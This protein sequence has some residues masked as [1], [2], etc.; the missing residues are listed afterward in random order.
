M[1]DSSASASCVIVALLCLELCSGQQMRLGSEG[2]TDDRR[3]RGGWGAATPGLRLCVVQRS[4]RSCKRPEHSAGSNRKYSETAS[5][6]PPGRAF[7]QS[8]PI[9][10]PLLAPRHLKNS[11]F[12]S[13]LPPLRTWSLSHAQGGLH[14]TCV[15]T[16]NTG[17]NT[18]SRVWHSS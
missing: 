8:E 7:R 14:T 10:L 15:Q 16:L 4:A 3:S 9:R 5:V 12:K 13:N 2:Y 1:R 17:T 11:T 6:V 18:S